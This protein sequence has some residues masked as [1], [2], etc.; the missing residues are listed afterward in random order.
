[1]S[2]VALLAVFGTNENFFDLRDLV[3]G[4]LT[5]GLLSDGPLMIKR[6]DDHDQTQQGSDRPSL[7][8]D[9]CLPH[10]ASFRLVSFAPDE[11]KIHTPTDGIAGIRRLI[12]S[13]REITFR[14]RAF[15]CLAEVEQI[16][17]FLLVDFLDHRSNLDAGIIGSRVS[18]HFEHR[19]AFGFLEIQFLLYVSVHFSDGD[20]EF[21]S[22][23][24]R[25]ILR[26][27]AVL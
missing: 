7:Q 1:M 6:I 12:G 25:F 15:Q 18:D 3:R 11:V 10:G 22:Q 26:H 13:D 9:A 8:C 19:H 17:D 21:L 24:H 27:A 2:V 4:S 20:A 5:I 23:T 16:S 14:H